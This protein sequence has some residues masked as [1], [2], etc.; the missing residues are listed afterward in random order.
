MSINPHRPRR[1]QGCGRY[2]VLPG[3]ASGVCV[4][5]ERDIGPGLGDIDDP[6]ELRIEEERLERLAAR[7]AEEERAEYLDRLAER[8]ME[9]DAIRFAEEREEDRDRAYQDWE[10]STINEITNMEH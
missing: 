2:R 5:C 9:E 4:D 6:L 8:E 10:R 3:T 7:R 1:C